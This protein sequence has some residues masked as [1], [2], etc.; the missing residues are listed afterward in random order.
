ML[1]NE[2]VDGHED[3]DVDKRDARGTRS[4][5]NS[6]MLKCCWVRQCY[7]RML[8]RVVVQR[9][10]YSSSNASLYFLQRYG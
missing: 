5:G 2:D 8:D 9:S 4:H 7:G 6:L 10:H 1:I 3:V